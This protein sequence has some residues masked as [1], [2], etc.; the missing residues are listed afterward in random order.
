MDYEYLK[1]EV[2][3]GVDKRQILRDEIKRTSDMDL[4]SK[5]RKLL[6]ENIKKLKLNTS[7]NVYKISYDSTSEGLEPIYFWI[8]DFFKDSLPAGLEM[9]E[10]IKYKDEYDAS[11]A[12]GYFGEMG[13]RL[14]VMQDRAMKIMATVNTVIRSIINII[15]DL[16]EF[17]IRLAHYDNFHSGISSTRQAARL[18]LKQLWMDQVDIKKSRGSINALSQQL[19][20]VTLRDAFLFVEK[21]EKIDELDINERVKRI[22]KARLEEYFEWE[23]NSET[24]LRKRYSIERSYLKSQVA[25]LK[26]YTLWVKPYLVAA[27]KLGMTSF[28]SSSGR[29]SPNLVNAFSNMEMHLGLFGMKEVKPEKVIK[30]Y[31]SMKFERK[32][33]SCIEVDIVFRTIP[34]SVQGQYGSHYVHSGRIDLI[35]TPYSFTDEEI[36]EIYKLKEEED[37]E[38]IEEMTG[39]S[40]KEIQ[41]DIDHYLKDEDESKLEKLKG[42]DKIEELKRRIARATTSAERNSL[43]IQLDE[44]IIFLKQEGVDRFVSPFGNLFKGFKQGFEPFR[45]IVGMFGFKNV[46]SSPEK[47]IKKEALS[48]PNGAEDMNYILYDIY[49]KAHGM[50]TW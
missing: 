20:F 23:K 43:Q 7:K 18:A 9:D 25:S 44:E 24:E 2:S 1:K 5:L 37:F 13:T 42:K 41:E 36:K 17:S 29:Q 31:S 34:R 26:Y 30:G 47:Y 14:S 3:K 11:V 15:Y 19:E 38:L 6:V 27:Q 35:F 50:V 16:R 45:N 21:L 48:G 8:L 39:T 12:S 40:L 33:Y 49:K 10:I 28:A 32:F 46:F 4:K 22:L